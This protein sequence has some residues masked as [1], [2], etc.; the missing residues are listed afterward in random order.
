MYKIFTQLNQNINW[1]VKI[2]I[3]N[4]LCHFLLFSYFI[5]DTYHLTNEMRETFYSKE[6][7]DKFLGTVHQ[8][9]ETFFLFS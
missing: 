7:S 5:E 9:L 8:I 1:S 3:V 4:V 6:G 2:T